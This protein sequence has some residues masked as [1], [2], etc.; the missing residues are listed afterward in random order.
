MRP[1]LRLLPLSISAALSLPALANDDIP[2]N[3]NFC[4]VH[5]AIPAFADAADPE[6]DLD[7]AI[8]RSL[9]ADRPTIIE[10]D[11]QGGTDQNMLF[12]GNVALRR[13]DQFLGADSISFSP[14]SDTYLAEGNVRYQDS[15][16]RVIADRAHGD[17]SAN[18]HQI[19]NIR[20]QLVSHRGHGN[21]ESIIMTDDTGQLN[22]AT[23][24]T[25]D[26]E[27][28]HWQ[29][30]ARRI[31]ADMESGWATARAATIR[32]G[33]VP[34]LYVPWI[35]FPT[36]DRRHTGLLY[37]SIS[38]SGRN[39]FDYRQPIYLNIAPNYDATITPR[40]MS[41][42]GASLATQ[43]RYLLPNGKG[44]LQTNWMPSDKLLEEHALE[45]DYNPLIDPAPGDSRGS[46]S[47][48]GSHDISRNWQARASI[49]WISDVRYTED[50]NSSLSGLSSSSL[51][52]TAGLYGRGRYWNA[53]LMA[54]TWLLADH[55]LGELSLPYNRLP[56][57]FL[58]WEQPLGNLFRAGLQAETVRFQHDRKGDGSRLDLKPYISMPL[59]GAAW[60]LNPTLAWR[61]TGYELE[62]DL[63]A[64][65]PGG[66][67]SPSRSLP[68]TT[69]DAGL[70][71]DRE[72]SFRGESFL[73]TLEPRLFYLNV[74]YRDQTG[75][76]L[77]D[78]RP[79]TF[80]WGQ[81]FR[82][83]RYSGPDRQTDANQLTLALSTRL[84]RHRDGR[85]KLSA[86]LGQITYFEDSRVVAPG[87]TPVEQGRS[88]WIADG[89]YAI[90][91]RWTLGT[92]YQWD[93]KFRRQ[94]LVSVRSRYL[95]G[96][97]GIINLTYRNRRNLL[98]QADLSFLY[99]ISPSWSAVGRYYYSLQ[100]NQL[101]EGIAG[102]QWES[103]CLAVR[104][105]VRRYVRNREGDLNTS[106]MVEF[107]LKGLGSAGRDTEGVLRNAI[108]GY[109]RDDLY[110]V[111]PD[112]TDSDPDDLNLAPD[113]L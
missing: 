27:Q 95:I 18:R 48:I 2:H 41:E 3:W 109:H 35:K 34:V 81:L 110:L 51:T 104:T 105:V 96:N 79:F 88:A 44:T 90:N 86:S 49:N 24:T 54:D 63:A 89:N 36:D 78:T 108:L 68:I 74:P 32:L 59:Q 111:A 50:F 94:D 82:D 92:S 45:P 58:N 43:F 25:C 28:A 73:H 37:P 42:R 22:H 19:D 70:F 76:P 84:L 83:N 69:V 85:E 55:T 103:C 31:D 15:G 61:Y 30:R 52:S 17:Q 80:S 10:G 39:G 93:P 20:Y 113:P 91:D 13:G 102:L 14:V 60:Y 65:M 101:L 26:P 99:P 9:R 53:G 100:D 67:T 66:D 71:F 8:S 106:F 97:D 11:E 62:D 6:E 64:V 40:Y 1:A 87:E 98:E 112:N 56:R 4:A 33:N 46:F 77:F 23:Y 5:D 38:T 12:I 75:L 21:A 57:L 72:T 16:L 7:A 47:F 29:L 107:V